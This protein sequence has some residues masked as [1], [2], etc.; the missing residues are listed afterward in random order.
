MSRQ[1]IPKAMRFRVLSRDGYKCRYCGASAPDVVLHLDHVL[2][3]AKGGRNTD[4]NLVTACLP[5]NIGKGVTDATPPVFEIV[6]NPSGKRPRPR[7]EFFWSRNYDLEGA[8]VDDARCIEF[9]EHSEETHPWEWSEFNSYWAGRKRK[10]N[11]STH[12]A[13]TMGFSPY[14]AAMYAT[15]IL[16]MPWSGHKPY[17]GFCDDLTEQAMNGHL[18]QYVAPQVMR[19]LHREVITERCGKMTWADEELADYLALQAQTAFGQFIA[20]EHLPW[21]G[22]CW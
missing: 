6:G 22:R 10:W 2:A 5:C 1:P 8:P 19:A 17:F 18:P 3:V 15:E 20:S 13:S 14:E 12:G 16:S 7:V 21:G 4:D 9:P 11:Y